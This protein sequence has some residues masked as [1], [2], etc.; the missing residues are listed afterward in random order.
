[1]HQRM[2]IRQ[3]LRS[4]AIA[5]AS[6]VSMAPALAIPVSWVGQPNE[7]RLSD[8]PAKLVKRTD[9]GGVR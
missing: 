6:V 1:M 4:I 9:A 8:A 2:V 5:A 3:S 7:K